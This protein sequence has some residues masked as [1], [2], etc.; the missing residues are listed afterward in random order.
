MASELNAMNVY[1][2][3][4]CYRHVAFCHCRVLQVRK[5]SMAYRE[6]EEEE[7]EAVTLR[8]ASRVAWCIAFRIEIL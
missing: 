4:L 3:Y 8:G 1:H 6:V 2:S 7:D 5:Q